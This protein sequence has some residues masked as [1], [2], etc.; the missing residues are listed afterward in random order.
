MKNG[1]IAL[2]SESSG[3]LGSYGS[4]PEAGPQVSWPSRILANVRRWLDRRCERLALGRLDERMLKDIGVSRIDAERE[5][6]KPF[7]QP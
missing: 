3:A 2:M 1:N 5:I 4:I 7:W 6:E